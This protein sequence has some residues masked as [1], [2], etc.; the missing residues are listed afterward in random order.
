MSNEH[1]ELLSAARR[2]LDYFDNPDHPDCIKDDVLIRLREVVEDTT[3]PRSRRSR[4]MLFS[5]NIQVQTYDNGWRGSV[6]LP[7]LI[8][9][10]DSREHLEQILTPLIARLDGP[11]TYHAEEV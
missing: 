5:V 11:A 3:T 1:A 7:N 9:R 10:A 4:P 6:G 8:I 2:V